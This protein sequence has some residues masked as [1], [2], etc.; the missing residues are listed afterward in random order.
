MRRKKGVRLM[1]DEMYTG[2]KEYFESMGWE[3]VTVEDAG[4]RG[5]RDRD[6]VEYA[7]RRKLLIVTQDPKVSDLASLRGVE[8]VLVSK[9]ALAKLI[10]SEIRKRLR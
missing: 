8:C 4:L 2:L 9:L 5:A 6:L 10:D 1:L 3:V 7:R